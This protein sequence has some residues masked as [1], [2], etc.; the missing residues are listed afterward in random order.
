MLIIGSTA[1]KNYFPDFNRTPK[2]LDYAVEDSTEFRNA[3]GVE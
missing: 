2:D 3:N 1:I